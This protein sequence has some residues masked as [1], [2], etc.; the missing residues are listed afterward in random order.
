MRVYEPVDISVVV[1]SYG[2]ES[3]LVALYERLTAVL[4]PISSAFEIVIVDDASPLADWP[5]IR[6]LAERDTRV[7]GLRL[8]RN[9]GQHYAIAAGLE[10]ARGERVIVMDCDLQDRP[11]DIPHLYEKALEGFACVFARRV[12]RQ[13]PMT[14]IAASKGFALFNGWLSGTKADASIGNFS[15]ISRRVVQELRRFNERNRNYAMQVHWLGFPTAYVEVEHAQRHSG[16]SAYTLRRQLRHAVESVLS[17]STRPLL[18]SAVLGLLMAVGA[19]GVGAGLVVRK[20]TTGFGVPGWASVMVSLFFLFGV[21]FLNLG[22]FGLY[23]GSIFNEV[24][25]RPVFVI[26]ETTFDDQGCR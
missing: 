19:G 1:P 14:K 3:C 22:I 9:F 25:R 18:A 11:E 4:E 12:H 20:L 24:K 6:A 15:I 10:H 5:G 7:R 13:D 23:L 16:R 8:A 17:Q 2:C 26:S 21:L